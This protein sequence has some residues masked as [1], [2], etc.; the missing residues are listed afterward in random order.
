MAKA[1]IPGLVPI[2]APPDRPTQPGLIDEKQLRALNNAGGPLRFFD[3][4]LPI[5]DVA[6]ALLSIQ[7]QMQAQ[8]IYGNNKSLIG[9]EDFNVAAVKLRA[10]YT[11][12]GYKD[13]GPSI[14]VQNTS[15]ANRYTVIS[16]YPPEGVSLG[17]FHFAT[18][19]ALIELAKDPTPV[20]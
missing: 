11:P 18:A 4:A 8:S 9:I 14:V 13:P 5:E 17:H 16:A 3:A 1:N 10:S 7:S 19:V 2:I 12:A 15:F 20:Q 6:D